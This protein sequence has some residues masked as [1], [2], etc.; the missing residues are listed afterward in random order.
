MMELQFLINKITAI[1]GA[2]IGSA[3]IS[4]FWTPPRLREKSRL[5]AGIMIGGVSSGSAVIF[6]GFIMQKL[7]FS[8]TDIDN[9]LAVGGLIGI[10]AMPVMGWIGNYLHE[11]E[12]ETITDVA[13]EL[14]N[15]EADK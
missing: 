2:L 10:L 4:V 3:G 5:A 1:I 9:I 12:D 7:G 15:G 13:K 8:P 11:K 14:K 6:S